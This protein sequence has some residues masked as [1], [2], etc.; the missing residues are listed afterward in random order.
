MHYPSFW[1]RVCRISCLPSI[2]RFITTTV[3][4]FIYHLAIPIYYLI[5]YLEW[6]KYTTENE[7]VILI[8]QAIRR[9]RDL[10]LVD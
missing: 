10:K 8:K 5:Q 1:I 2:R 4:F 9:G 6:Q 3:L 7:A